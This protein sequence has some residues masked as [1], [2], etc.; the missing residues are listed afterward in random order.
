V[1]PSTPSLCLY[2]PLWGATFDSED[3]G[4]VGG[5]VLASIPYDDEWTSIQRSSV[6]RARRVNAAGDV[7]PPLCL[8]FHCRYGAGEDLQQAIDRNDS[9]GRT[10]VH[11]AALA[12]RLLRPGWF[13][14]PEFAE[15]CWASAHQGW[16]L[17]RIPG[18][19]R[20]VA[21]GGTID[22]PLPPY[23]LAHADLGTAAGMERPLTRLHASL[24]ATTGRDDDASTDIATEGFNRSYAYQFTPAQRMAHL[25]LAL[26]TMLGG[27]SETRPGGVQMRARSG[28]FR[29]RVKAALAAA[30]TEPIECARRAAWLNGGEP[31]EGRWLRNCIAHGDAIGEQ[32]MTSVLQLQDLV[33]A[34][35]RQYLYFAARWIADRRTILQRF[36]LPA[37]CGLVGAY[38]TA[39]ERHAR[40]TGDTADLLSASWG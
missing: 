34:I 38:N 22:P 24:A 25:F 9:Q 4:R 23:S 30:G 37:D 31:G 35:L 5:Q 32:P 36:G 7:S 33:R 18:P 28:G 26:D 13:L 27:M 8:T 12:L 40:N 39:L 1:N 29:V 10:Q 16:Q 14:D 2:A 20:Q 21:L 6:A 17:Q 19:Y 11:R 3:A 15:M